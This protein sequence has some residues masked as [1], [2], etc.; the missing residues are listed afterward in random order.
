MRTKFLS[1][2]KATIAVILVLLWLGTGIDTTVTMPDNAPVYLDDGARSYI[3]LP[4][5]EEWE[6][7]TGESFAFV[8]LGTAKEAHQLHYQPDQDCRDAG[9]FMEDNR[10]LTGH[11]LVKL[12]ILPPMQHWWNRP[13]R[14]ETG[15]VVQ[16]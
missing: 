1:M 4:C 12:G 10:S 2:G 13:Y 7:R 8:H 3:A 5:I 6:R 9:A 16:P 15:E 14:T 11:L